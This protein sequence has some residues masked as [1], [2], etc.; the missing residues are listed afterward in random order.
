VQDGID[1]PEVN[2]VATICGLQGVPV[3]FDGEAD[4]Q[5][6]QRAGDGPDEH[7]GVL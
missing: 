2:S 3:P 7:K 4:E 5:S 6:A 1:L